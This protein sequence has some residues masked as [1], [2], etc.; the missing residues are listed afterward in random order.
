MSSTDHQHLR[1]HRL[2][3][4]DFRERARGA[5]G[6]E[7]IDLMLAA[8]RSRRL[9]MVGL[10]LDQLKSQPSALGP[11]PHYDTAWAALL[12]A[13][14]QD[15]AAVEKVLP[16]LLDLFATTPD[17]DRGLLAYRK[18]SEALAETP[19]YLR[20]LRDEGTVVDRLAALLGTSK[21]VPD[22]LVRARSLGLD[23]PVIGVAYDGTG[24]GTDGTAWGAA[25][26]GSPAASTAR[27]GR[28]P[29]CST[30]TPSTI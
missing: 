24:Y 14:E 6:A 27:R 21:L 9:V 30:T 1:R 25:A 22:L 3:I 19:W 13:T 7:T 15:P 28:A 23:G 18:V 16:V 26:S 11:L 2:P 5:G 20:L 10:L 4:R 29:R 12:E 8:E 17:P